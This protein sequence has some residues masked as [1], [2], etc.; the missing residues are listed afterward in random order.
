M[1]RRKPRYEIT[2]FQQAIRIVQ[3][4]V[5]RL[6][7][8]STHLNKLARQ[9]GAPVY[10]QTISETIRNNRETGLVFSPFRQWLH[11]INWQ[12]VIVDSDGTEYQVT[13]ASSLYPT[14][15]NLLHL[16]GV[17]VI[18]TRREWPTDLSSNLNGMLYGP[19][20]KAGRD[21]RMVSLLRVLHQLNAKLYLYR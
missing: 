8:G 5:Q 6:K 10:M 7:I 16:A 15:T 4:E 3:E 20:R 2:G 9:F 17:S 18:E 21:V 11:V 19:T 1:S 12:L 13:D 14:L